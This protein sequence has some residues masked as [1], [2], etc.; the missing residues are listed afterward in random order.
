MTFGIL[1][2]RKI[3][4]QTINQITKNEIKNGKSIYHSFPREK[5]TW[6]NLVHISE[7]AHISQLD[8]FT[9]WSEA[10]TS[11]C[12]TLT[13]RNSRVCYYRDRHS[14][15]QN[16]FSYSNYSNMYLT[17]MGYAL[18]KIN[19]GQYKVESE[20]SSAFLRSIQEVCKVLPFPTYLELD[21]LHKVQPKNIPQ[22]IIS[23]SRFKNPVSSIL[24]DMKETC[25]DVKQCHFSILLWKM[26][27]SFLKCY[28]C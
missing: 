5:R 7:S 6:N 21:F 20:N 2:S 4:K 3:I 14:V 8:V 18:K 17:S 12:L 28:L 23:R 26:K 27:F 9:Q 16:H 1:L 15:V 25:Q 24:P 13:S 19:E 10:I 22:Q 11:L